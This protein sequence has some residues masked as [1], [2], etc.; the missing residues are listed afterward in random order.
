MS[1]R[2]RSVSTRAFDELAAEYDETL[3]IRYPSIRQFADHSLIELV[4]R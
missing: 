4:R 2:G 3:Y 1:T